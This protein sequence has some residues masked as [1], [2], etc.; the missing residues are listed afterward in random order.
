MS[1]NCPLHEAET[2]GRATQR[3]TIPKPTTDRDQAV[4]LD[5]RLSRPGSFN[6]KV[7]ANGDLIGQRS[8]LLVT[9]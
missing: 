2:L 6:I 3:I 4:A 1:S 7:T 8:F 9:V 5:L